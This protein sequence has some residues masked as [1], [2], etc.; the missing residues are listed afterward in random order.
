MRLNRVLPQARIIEMEAD[1]AEHFGARA[2]EFR[3]LMGKLLAMLGG[4]TLGSGSGWY[5]R[6][7]LWRLIFLQAK[8]GSWEPS[9]SLAFALQVLLRGASHPIFE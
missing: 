8:D 6:A 7:Q 4:G 5:A 1:S 3:T 2:D 9:Q